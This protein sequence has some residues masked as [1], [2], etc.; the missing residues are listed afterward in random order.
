M[1]SNPYVNKVQLADGT[2]VLDISDTTAVASDVASGKYFYLASGQKVQGSASGGT[3]AISVV[4]TTDTAGGTVRTITAV[5]ISDTTAVASDV[6]SGKYFYTS[7][8]VKTAGT[9]SGGGG[10]LEYE[11]GTWTPS[12]DTLYA[13]ISFA[14]SH[15]T[16]PFFVGLSDVTDDGSTLDTGTMFV[17]S[18]FNVNDLFGI[19]IGYGT[20]VRYG[21][22]SYV[23]LNTGSLMSTQSQIL[24]TSSS[25]PADSSINNSRFNVT[26]TGFKAYGN[27]SGTQWKSAG[28][29]KW[30]AVWAPTT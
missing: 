20:N 3:A 18:Y 28:T 22:V 19:G 14:R 5:D 4:D 26:E 27:N 13:Q 7:S 24:N 21:N 6:A 9:A 8:G 30:I 16:V 2:S 25:D 12:E 17:W 15:T 29:Y 23:R 10:G 1:A 11:S